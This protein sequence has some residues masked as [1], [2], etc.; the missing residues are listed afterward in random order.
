M[1]K[2]KVGDLVKCVNADGVKYIK[3]NNYYTVRKTAKSTI[4][5]LI[6]VEDHISG[7]DVWFEDRRFELSSESNSDDTPEEIR[8][9]KRYGMEDGRQL[10]EHYE[11]MFTADEVRGFYK[12]NIIKYITRYSEKNGIADLE[13]AD[14]YLDQLAEFEK[15]KL[16]ERKGN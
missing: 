11:E 7:L 13:K 6:M 9:T 10:F 3:E 12:L 14:V 5:G 15:G 8:D 4:S 2:F 1:N 16:D